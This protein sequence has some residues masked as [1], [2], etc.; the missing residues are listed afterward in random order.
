MSGPSMAVD[1]MCSSSLTTIHLACQ[2][3][4]DQQCRM[5]IA[6]GVNLSL[7]PN[8]YILL[9]QGKFVSTVGRCESFGR[10]GDGYVPSEGVG[11]VL[12]KPLEDAER[13]GDHIYGVIKGTALNHGGKTNGYTVPNPVAQTA[14]IRAALERADIA[15]QAISYVEAHGTGTS[16]GDPIEISALAR[17]YDGCASQ[18]CAIGSIKSNIGH[19]ESAAGIAG[20]TKV[21]LQLA[22][23]Q[24]VPSIHSDEL[25]PHLDIDRTPFRVQR[26]LQD[27]PRPMLDGREQP[28]VAAI[29]S[30]GAGGS[31][32]HVI[33]AEHISA[34][35]RA[36]RDRSLAWNAD[37]MG[38]SNNEPA[39]FLLS[40]RTD[41]RLRAYAESWRDFLARQ[42]A[43]EQTQPEAGADRLADIAYT[44]QVG[45]EAMKHRLAI[46]AC[47]F[48]ELKSKLDAFCNGDTAQVYLGQ[49][50]R[51]DA[52]DELS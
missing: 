44:L 39:L 21:L 19:C 30:F 34:E 52:V 26:Q 15:P 45:R 35:R 46:L 22:H 31:N 38:N 43:A 2:S 28:R 16:L 36:G 29:S 17:A 41:E 3:L 33:I 49:V 6:G 7:H 32:A 10:G 14:V 23:G 4:R 24:L 37:S 27:W 18:Q 40:A 1:T 25:N 12:L 51:Q 8:K 9:S 20:V 47:D 50:D 42:R 48:A 5:A 11:C 13:D